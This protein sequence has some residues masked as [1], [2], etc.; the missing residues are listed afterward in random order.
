MMAG[1]STKK[2]AEVEVDVETN[3][4]DMMSFKK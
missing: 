4:R 3:G 2:V 1:C